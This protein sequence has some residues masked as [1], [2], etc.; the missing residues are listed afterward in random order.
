MKKQETNYDFNIG[1]QSEIK[2]SDINPFL[3]QLLLFKEII[4]L[5][6]HKKNYLNKNLTCLYEM[7]LAIIVL[8]NESN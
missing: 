3:L 8:N 4:S 5:E 7:I 2:V 1:N 6:L